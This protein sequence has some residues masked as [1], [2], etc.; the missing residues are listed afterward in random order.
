MVLGKVMVHCYM[1]M[2]RSGIFPLAYLV[3]KCGMSA[4]DAMACIRRRRNIHPNDGFIEQ[5]AVL[6]NKI[7]RRAAIYN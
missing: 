4:C 2:S 5:L 7:M 1:G 6:D 3:L